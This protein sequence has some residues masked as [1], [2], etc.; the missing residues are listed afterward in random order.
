MHNYRIEER[1]VPAKSAGTVCIKFARMVQGVPFI[2]ITLHI[3]AGAFIV[4]FDLQAPFSGEKG[5]KI[6]RIVSG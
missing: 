4:P 1:R 5:S 3:V 2:A 6:S